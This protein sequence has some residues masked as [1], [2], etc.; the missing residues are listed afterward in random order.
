[1]KLWL[2]LLSFFFIASVAAEE[3]IHEY[4]V[5]ISIHKDGS[6]LVTETI[7][8]NIEGV[9]IR[10][11]IYRDFPVH[12]KDKKG[13]KYKVDFEIISTQLDG[14][15]VANKLSD[16]Q[17]HKRLYLGSKSTLAPTGRHTYSISYRTNYQLGFFAEHDEL[18]WNAIGPDWVF[19]IDRARVRVMLPQQVAAASIKTEFYTGSYGAKE[20]AAKSGSLNGGAWFETSKG[21]PPNNGFTIVMSFPKGI[22]AE[23]TQMQKFERMLRD[24][25]AILS[26]F[27]GLLALLVWFI[28]IWNKIGRDPR[29]GTIIPRFKAPPGLSPAAVRYVKNMGFDD[30]AMSAAII[31]LAIKG[32]LRIHNPEKKEYSLEKID[33]G[34]PG[35]RLR[36][37][38]RG[39][40]ALLD[41][42]FAD[43][44]HSLE[45]DQK[46]YKILGQAKLA[47]ATA[48]K[49]E[50]HNKLFKTNSAYILPGVG[51]VLLTVIAMVIL[52]PPPP[53]VIIP[54][55]IMSL[56]TV[57]LF[58]FLLRAPTYSGRKAL[59][60]IEGLKMYL[61]TAESERLNRMKSPELTPQVFE[62]FLPF[63]FALGVQNDWS[64]IFKNKLT[65]ALTDSSGQANKYKP[66][67]YSGYQVSNLG[68]LGFLANMGDTLG[69][70]LSTA[71]TRSSS[72]PGSSSGSGG[73]GFSGGGGGGGG[74]GG[75]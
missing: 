71:V 45:L 65:Q 67:W 21:L 2:S 49:Q 43:G 52:G 69:S 35:V 12:Y 68:Q 18:Y 61:E 25:A 9:N 60:E 75:W 66:A 72:P 46:Q 64:D 74:G 62:T 48:L 7:D 39:E 34:D 4:L 40:Q 54:F 56:V 10:H 14:A 26:A 3:R 27:A 44:V 36:A 6:M 24:N 19:P 33:R 73:G 63:A 42:L 15:A 17:N 51:I 20:Q 57:T 29:P 50:Y 53:W 59:D 38:S 32:H 58:A 30:K 16:K 23:P 28:W 1:M 41:A 8:V 37:L 13:L 22:I 31:S 55:V 11:G 47:L 70:Q 5:D